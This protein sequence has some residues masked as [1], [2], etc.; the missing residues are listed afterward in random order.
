MRACAMLRMCTH[1]CASV[2]CL[3]MRLLLTAPLAAPAA[4]CADP[5]D[6]GGVQHDGPAL[7]CHGRAAA[8]LQLLPSD[9][10]C[11]WPSAKPARLQA[12]PR[13][14]SRNGDD[15]SLTS[16]QL[17][18][19]RKGESRS[20]SGFQ[21]SLACFVHAPPAHVLGIPGM[22]PATLVCWCPCTCLE[23]VAWGDL[24]LWGACTGHSPVLG[25]T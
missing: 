6:G 22:A 23:W 10:R 24:V 25:L 16:V 3:A 8:H 12:C 7:L 13:R 4:C 20:T 14:A 5:A 9:T 21:G 18:A 19:E 15:K 1:A 11:V 2:H 17:G